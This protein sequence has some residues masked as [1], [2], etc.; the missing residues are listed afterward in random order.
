[1]VEIEFFDPEDAAAQP[2]GGEEIGR[3]PSRQPSIDGALLSACLL[4][5]GAAVLAVVAS[6]QQVYVIRPP[7][8]RAG[9]AY[10]VDGWGRPAS[11]GGVFVPSGFREPRYGIALCVAA[12]ISAGIAATILIGWTRSGRVVRFV[13]AAAAGVGLTGL[14]AGISGAMWL[15]VDAALTRYRSNVQTDAAGP[16]AIEATFGACL[17]LAAAAGVAAAIGT[18]ALLRRRRPARPSAEDVERHG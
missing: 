2:D 5:A 6:F 12:A 14:I 13:P 1:M 3:E 15:V 16:P 10:S 8:G 9:P 18:G 4:F 11:E 17:W 7:G